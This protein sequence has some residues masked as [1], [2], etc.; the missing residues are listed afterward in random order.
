VYACA[1]WGSDSKEVQAA[2]ALVHTEACV[3]FDLDF[4]FPFDGRSAY[5]DHR[6]VDKRELEVEWR[7]F[8]VNGCAVLTNPLANQRLGAM[9]QAVELVLKQVDHVEKD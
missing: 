9:D 1:I 8:S 2:L 7:A 5:P 6:S 3:A 4:V